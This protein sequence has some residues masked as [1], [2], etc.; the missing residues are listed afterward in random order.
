MIILLPAL[1]FDLHLLKDL[2]NA[3]LPTKEKEGYFEGWT[4]GYGL[5]EMAEFVKERAK[6][7]NVLLVTAGTFG[8][9]PDGIGIYLFENPNIE[10]WYS[11]SYLEPYVYEAAKE[12]ETY[13]I[14]HKS[15][16]V[17]N[18]NLSLIKEINK[19]PWKETPSDLLLLFKV[20]NP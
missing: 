4:A 1:I 15:N 12:K 8:T 14:V 7:K 19:P 18:P 5:K 9:L 20:E 6:E 3:N 10:I 2:Q 11:N 17:T 13:F 16:F